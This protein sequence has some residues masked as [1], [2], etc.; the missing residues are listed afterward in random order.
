MTDLEKLNQW[1]SQGVLVFEPG[2]IERLKRE[3][4]GAPPERVVH[5]N[6][7][8]LVVALIEALPGKRFRISSL[9]R[10]G[11]SHGEG[12][13]VDIGNEEI[14]GELLPLVATQ[15]VVDRLS[16]DE[17]IFDASLIP[18]EKNRNKYNFDAGKPHVY[19]K[20]TLDE[21]RDHIHF[22]IRA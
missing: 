4:L 20:S 2:K 3:L 9:L 8:A 19:N 17:I 5:P 15:T 6:V 12:R 11:G 18:D 16:L 14:A 21:H 22:S 13:A 10:N 7:R 1:I